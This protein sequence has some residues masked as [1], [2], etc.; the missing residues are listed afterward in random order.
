[1]S[2]DDSISSS[3]PEAPIVLGVVTNIEGAKKEL[4]KHCRKRPYLDGTYYV[5]DL[6]KSSLN[7]IIVGICQLCQT[8]SNK[9]HTIS[10]SLQTP[11]NY[12]THIKKVHAAKH[13]E[14]VEYVAC[15]KKKLNEQKAELKTYC[16]FSQSTFESNIVNFILETMSPMNIVEHPAFKRIFDDFCIKKGGQPLTH[17]SARTIERR[18]HD[19]YNENINKLN[20]MIINTQ[21]VC[22]TADTWS[23]KTRRFLGMTVHWIDFKTLQRK[24]YALACRRLT[25]TH[26]YDRVARLIED[27]HTSFGMDKTKVLATVTDNGSNFVKAFGES[28]LNI[29]DS[30]FSETAEPFVNQIDNESN[31]N[32]YAEIEEFVKRDEFESI[33]SLPEHIRCASH[34]LNLVVTTDMIKCIKSYKFLN[35]GYTEMIQRCELIWKLLASPKQNEKLK[36]VLGQSLKKPVITRWNSFYDALLQI[37]GLKEKILSSSEELGISNPLSEANFRFMEEYL[38]CNRSIAA[39]INILQGDENSPYGYLL[40]TLLT[41]KNKLHHC[42]QLKFQHCQKLI[43]GI[44]KGLETRFANVFNVVDEGRTCA[45]AAATHPR[46]KLHWLKSL[47]SDAQ[48]NVMVAL[49]EALTAKQQETVTEEQPMEIADDFFEFTTFPGNT[50]ETVLKVHNFGTSDPELIYQQFLADKNNDIS[51]LNSYPVIK[52]IFVKFNTPLPSSASVE[53]LFSYATMFNLPKFNRLTDSNF[54]R[55]VVMKCNASISKQDKK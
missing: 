11:S 1:M 43:L 48:S 21:Y 19:T 47:S 26:S 36:D 20:E 13:G 54:E 28:G 40:P 17:L 4:A 14:Y 51:L 41:I 49:K 31:E 46:F 18:I 27:I 53:R 25:G 38:H 5:P 2:E 23:S 16:N 55:R 10:G 37:F 50:Q 3:Q 15:K 45:V 42:K 8:E 32:D 30:F 35:S 12:N 39:A 34:T 24:S 44:E 7:G 29:G 33:E 52:Q 22:T 9:L 6:D